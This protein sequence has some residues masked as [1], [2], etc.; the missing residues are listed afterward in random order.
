MLYLKRKIMSHCSVDFRIHQMYPSQC[1][2]IEPGLYLGGLDAAEQVETLRHLRITHVLTV[3]SFPITKTVMYD[4]HYLFIEAEDWD[5]ENLLSSFPIAINFIKEGQKQGTCLVHC[6]AGIS[7]SA[8]VVIAFLM[9]KYGLSLTEAL[10]K[11]EEKRPS[12]NPNKGFLNQLK[13]FEVMKYT[14]DTENVGY[15]IFA[16]HHLRKRVTERNFEFIHKYV[17][18][19]TRNK[20]CGRKLKC[21][22]CRQYLCSE[23]SVIP[24]FEG[25]D[26]YGID[27]ELQCYESPASSLCKGSTLLVE[28]LSWM[29]DI[30][31]SLEG[32]LYCHKCMKKIG[33]F[34][35]KGERCFCGALIAPCFKICR[36]KVDE[37]K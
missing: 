3:A 24:H 19:F 6:L 12:I 36:S 8:T 20:S 23:S 14:I 30:F 26:L 33:T 17:E 11:V 10:K 32:K 7:R 4:V 2:K 22:Q 31:H 37:D 16:L 27:T 9:Q 1:N 13:L 18:E 29:A 34:D 5:D 35:W 15:K 21:K 28:P 25:K